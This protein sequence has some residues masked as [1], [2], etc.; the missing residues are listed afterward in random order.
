MADT[1]MREAER[2]I[3]RVKTKRPTRAAT[4]KKMAAF[5]STCGV[6]LADVELEHLYDIA[7][8]TD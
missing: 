4:I 2:A 5:L 7:T 1:N 3:A 8:G 6:G